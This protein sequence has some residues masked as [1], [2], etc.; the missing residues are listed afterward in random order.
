MLKVKEVYE[1]QVRL[2][3]ERPDGATFVSFG[4]V[5][6]SRPLLLNTAYIVSV[7]PCEFTSDRD[8]E[9]VNAAFPEGTSFCTLVMDGNS[10]RKSEVTVVGS[11]NKFCQMLGDDRK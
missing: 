1:K 5:F 9:K 4:K 2:T 11:F 10:F 8:M 6:D 7:Q 3:E